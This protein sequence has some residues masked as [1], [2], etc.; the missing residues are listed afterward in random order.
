MIG[1]VSHLCSGNTCLLIGLSTFQFFS[2]CVGIYSQTPVGKLQIC[3]LGCDL[4][5]NCFLSRI[6]DIKS[7]FTWIKS[8][9]QN[10]SSIFTNSI[11]YFCHFARPCIQNVWL[12]RSLYRNL[13]GISFLVFIH[14][15]IGIEISCI[16]C[17]SHVGEDFMVGFYIFC[18]W[19]YSKFRK[20]IQGFLTGIYR[21]YI[22]QSFDFINNCCKL[23]I[24][25]IITSGCGSCNRIN[26]VNIRVIWMFYY[27][28]YK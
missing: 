18:S 6:Q 14:V 27:V 3:A 5:C 23:L 8:H 22:V 28:I 12:I 21:L 11:C 16:I 2:W 24:L 4:F 7:S 17:F 1:I 25:S 9:I 20:S 26:L 13:S 10:S 15:V 19:S